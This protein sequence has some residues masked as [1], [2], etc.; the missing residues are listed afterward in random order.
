MVMSM[1]I[2]TLLV[3][4]CDFVKT[5]YFKK[6]NKLLNSAFRTITWR[7]TRSINAFLLTDNHR[8]T[9]D[10]ESCKYQSLTRTCMKKFFLS[11][12][13]FYLASFLLY[14]FGTKVFFFRE[15][16]LRMFTVCLRFTILLYSY[17]PFRS[18]I[19]H[20]ARKILSIY[21]IYCIVRTLMQYFTRI[22]YY[23]R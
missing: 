15:T 23:I 5:R 11:F 10:E 13:T 14:I 7:S 3:T 16:F 19:L 18:Y 12:L 22:I 4:P 21:Y 1:F 17:F 8:R 6:Y 2:T 20:H 9:K